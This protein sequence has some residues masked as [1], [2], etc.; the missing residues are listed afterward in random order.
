MDRKYYMSILWAILPISQSVKQQTDFFT[1]PA[2][3]V[4][5]QLLYLVK[6]SL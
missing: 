1:S 2:G 3:Y 6:L 4:K 5:W